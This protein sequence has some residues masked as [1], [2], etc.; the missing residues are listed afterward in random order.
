VRAE[1]LRPIYLEVSL[2]FPRLPKFTG[3][4]LPAFYAAV[5]SR[6]PF[7]RCDANEGFLAT[8]RERRFE[9]DRDELVLSEELRTAFDVAQKNAVD[10]IGEA[11]K[12]E[13]F[14]IRLF[15]VESVKIRAL[16]PVAEEFVPVSDTLRDKLLTLNEDHFKF[17]GDVESVPVEFVGDSPD[18]FRHWHVRLD[19]HGGDDSL[20]YI[21]LENYFFD[22]L[23]DMSVVG[24]YLKITHDFLT[25]NVTHFV[26]SF[27][28]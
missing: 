23:R 18:P 10:L 25:H 11:A 9:I 22:P 21:V 24:E 20:L 17:L 12:P 19:G 28:Q 2:D 1:D 13:H 3:D 16:W 8:E 27:M 15:K 6:H 26:N 7:E 4:E 5:H 14:N